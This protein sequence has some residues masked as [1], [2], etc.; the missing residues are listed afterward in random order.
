ML[1]KGR[2]YYKRAG[3]GGG[4]VRAFMLEE[5][6]ERRRYEDVT[7]GRQRG[8]GGVHQVIWGRVIWQLLDGPII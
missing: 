3:T 6:H 4:R 7:G 1:V 5:N 2:G 8:V